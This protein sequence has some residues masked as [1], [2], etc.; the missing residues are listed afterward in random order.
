MLGIRTRFESNSITVLQRVEEAF[1]DWRMI[2]SRPELLHLESAV[3]RIVVRDGIEDSEPSY[4][5]HVTPDFRVVLT[6]R[7]SVM[8]SDPIRREVVG[9]ITP[10]L[11]EQR[12]QFRYGFLESSTLAMLTRLDRQPVHAAAVVRD[13]RA[14]L[15]CAPSGT[16]KSTLAYALARSGF[17]ILSDD[18]IYVESQR[19]LR[20][21]GLPRFLHL[22]EES[23]RFFPELSSSAATLMANGKRKI[24]IDLRAHGLATAWPVAE[25]AGV[26]L[27]ER[28]AGPPGLE[29]APEHAVLAAL[30]DGLES[31]FDL[32][33]DT[34]GPVAQRIAKPGAWRLH[35][36][37][38]PFAAVAAIEKLFQRDLKTGTR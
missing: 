19:Q 13:G 3:V 24:A 35:L 25:N 30:T 27:L 28:R 12:Q 1:G 29:P 26:C 10:A 14:L 20:L 15:L 21:W 31:G 16:G 2:E 8:V 38:D 32:F 18:V 11:L 17:Q 7:G 5:H 33:A 22:T 23:R 36:G 37:S 6:S 9:W 34:I 4:Q